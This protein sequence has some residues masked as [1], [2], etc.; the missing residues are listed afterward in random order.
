MSLVSVNVEYP[1]LIVVVI[2]SGLLFNMVPFELSLGNNNCEVRV[3]VAVTPLL[4]IPT[5]HSIQ[6]RNKCE[7]ES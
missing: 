5:Y 6:C 1:G 4:S 7:Q 3:D 2:Y